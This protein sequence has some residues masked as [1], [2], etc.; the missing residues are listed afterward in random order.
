MHGM[1]RHTCFTT[2][3]SKPT[4]NNGAR[5][6]LVHVITDVIF[7]FTFAS[8]RT[9]NRYIPT[10]VPVFYNHLIHCLVDLTVFTNDHSFW[11]TRL[12]RF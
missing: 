9:N 3:I 2:S 5:T 12:V 6:I 1:L 8:L 10:C 11:T 4:G 7:L